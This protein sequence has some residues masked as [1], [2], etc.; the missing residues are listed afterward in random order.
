MVYLSLFSLALL[1]NGTKTF[2]DE[3]STTD[4]KFPDILDIVEPV[5]PIGPVELVPVDPVEPNIPIPVDP[6]PEE[7]D[8]AA[9]VEPTPGDKYINQMKLLCLK[10]RT[11]FKTARKMIR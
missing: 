3:I 11:S 2:A 9:S 10:E 8:T 4:N 1:G 5:G 6:A 7:T